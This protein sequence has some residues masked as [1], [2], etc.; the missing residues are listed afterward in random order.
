MR[1]IAEHIDWLP[2][3]GITPEFLMFEDTR[4]DIHRPHIL[5]MESRMIPSTLYRFGE[6]AGFGNAI[7]LSNCS[8][9]SI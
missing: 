4:R 5:P 3:Y 8:S 2:T 1:L 6:N 9:S 7:V